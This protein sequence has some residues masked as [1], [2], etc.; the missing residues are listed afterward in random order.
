MRSYAL[1]Q[2]VRDSQIVYISD[3]DLYM[4]YR[5]K[6]FFGSDPY[7]EMVLVRSVTDTGATPLNIYRV[8][9]VSKDIGI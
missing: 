2:Y 4:T 7:N 6:S 5:Y 8:K 1:W 9:S 3:F